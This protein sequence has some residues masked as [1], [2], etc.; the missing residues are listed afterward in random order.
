MKLTALA[1]AL[2]RL[3]PDQ[4]RV[5]RANARSAVRKELRRLLAWMDGNYPH[6]RKDAKQPKRS[7]RA[8]LARLR[9]RGYVQVASIVV[10]VLEAAGVD[11][12]EE[13]KGSR[14]EWYAPGWARAVYVANRGSM[15]A[16]INDLKK[17]K[18]DPRAR[19]LWLVENALREDDRNGEP[20]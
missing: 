12:R 1:K 3:S 10:P 2:R 7:R 18:A 17:L 8:T 6:V 16:A 5:A 14:Q 15:I 4:G 19:K 9:V 13:A 11:V 20:F